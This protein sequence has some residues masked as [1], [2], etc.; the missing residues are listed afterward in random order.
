MGKNIFEKLKW[1]KKFVKL[2]MTALI[3]A[4]AVYGGTLYSA[5]AMKPTGHTE[6]KKVVPFLDTLHLLK[7][8][9]R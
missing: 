7:L 4:I 9:M 8:A 6:T 3:G 1:D 5:E 2:S